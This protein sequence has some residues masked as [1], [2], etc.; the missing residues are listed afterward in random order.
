MINAGAGVDVDPA[1]GDY[2]IMTAQQNLPPSGKLGVMLD[3]ESKPPEVS[4]FG[5]ASGAEEAGVKK[6]DVILS[7]DNRRISS[8]SDI[9][10]ALMDKAVG[11]YVTVEVQRD[12]LILG[13][14]RH[15]MDVE[16]R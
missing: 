5:H 7:I 14:M 10:L 12:S 13:S 4:G 3:V 16:L 9:R 8:Y 1:M 6:G 2:L 11:E 15:R